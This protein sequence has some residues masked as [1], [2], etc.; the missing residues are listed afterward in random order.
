[1]EEFALAVRLRERLIR[2]GEGDDAGAAVVTDLGQAGW[3][4]ARTISSRG[5]ALSERARGRSGR[6]CVSW[7]GQLISGSGF[8]RVLVW[9]VNHQ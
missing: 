5:S 9:D 4:L 8:G 1:M 2:V 7:E 6:L 3:H